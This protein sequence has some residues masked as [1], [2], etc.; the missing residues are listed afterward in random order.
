MNATTKNTPA[1]AAEIDLGAMGMHNK[2][3]LT[4]ADG[5][6]LTLVDSDLSPAIV[7][8]ALMHGLKQKL[9]DAAAISRNTDTGRPASITDK[10]EAVREVYERLLSGQWNKTREGGGATGG[11]LFRALCRMYDGKKTPDALREFLGGKTD[12]EKAALRKNTKVAAI[13]ETIRAESAKTDG[14]D[15]DGLLGELDD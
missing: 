15:A 4:F 8:Q 1:V 10:Y 9:V 7:A 3:T 11:L 5:R 6:A 2:L 12:A 13:I 14:V